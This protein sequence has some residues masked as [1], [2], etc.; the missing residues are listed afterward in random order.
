MTCVALAIAPSPLGERRVARAALAPT[1]ELGS[2]GPSIIGVFGARAAR[3]RG[4]GAAL[5]ATLADAAVARYGAPPTV[6]AITTGA[7]AAAYWTALFSAAA[8]RWRP[9]VDD[10]NAM[11]GSGM[12][13]RDWVVATLHAAGWRSV[14]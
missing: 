8:R 12:A 10:P 6:E 13:V 3:R 9:Y 4:I 2:G 5:I 7:A 1:D 14:A 11:H